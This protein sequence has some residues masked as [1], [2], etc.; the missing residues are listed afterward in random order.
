MCQYQNQFIALST[1]W[2]NVLN[3]QNDVEVSVSDVFASSDRIDHVFIICW[4]QTQIK[5]LLQ[6]HTS[7][8][9]PGQIVPF[10][11][12]RWRGL[13]QNWTPLQL[14]QT[15]QD[16]SGEYLDKQHR[17]AVRCGCTCSALSLWCVRRLLTVWENVASDFLP[18]W[19]SYMWIQ[20]KPQH[21]HCLY[22]M[23]MVLW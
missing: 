23:W 22:L 13:F 19:S 16:Q 18:V 8:I 15:F 21:K 3:M 9:L 20:P 4:K 6:T 1:F 7:V 14:F 2:I 5:D 11:M 17:A 10:S 12:R